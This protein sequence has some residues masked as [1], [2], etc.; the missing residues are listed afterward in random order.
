MPGLCGVIVW[1]LIMLWVIMLFNSAV[2]A[3]TFTN[4]LF[5]KDFRFDDLMISFF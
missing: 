2:N 4:C 5:N 3:T 1:P